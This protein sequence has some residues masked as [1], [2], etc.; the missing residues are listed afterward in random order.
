MAIPQLIRSLTCGAWTA[1]GVTFHP[2]FLLGIAVDGI[3]EVDSPG[4]TTR[5]LLPRP[6]CVLYSYV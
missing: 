2:G 6:I 1:P 4:Q 5:A 3:D